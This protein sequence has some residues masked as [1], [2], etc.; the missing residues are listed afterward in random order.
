[1]KKRLDIVWLTDIFNNK[2]DKQTQ[3]TTE[4]EYRSEIFTASEA[5]FQIESHGLS[6][7]DFIE[8]VGQTVTYE[9]DTILDWLG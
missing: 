8:E 1:M 9:G 4:Q 7:A 6:Y 3:E 5:R 2:T